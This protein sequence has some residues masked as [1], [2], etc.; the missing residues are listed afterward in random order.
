MIMIRISRLIWLLSCYIS[1]VLLLC[2]SYSCSNKLDI[3]EDFDTIKIV[4]TQGVGDLSISLK[5][6][7]FVDT[8]PAWCKVSIVN[9]KGKLVVSDTVVSLSNQDTCFRSQFL[10]LKSGYYFLKMCD[11]Y[12]S[13]NNLMYR[14][15]N[16]KKS[17]TIKSEKDKKKNIEPI[18]K[19]V[20]S[21][22]N[23]TDSF[24]FFAYY[25]DDKSLKFLH[26]DAT[27]TL[28]TNG[29]PFSTGSMTTQVTAV[30]IPRDINYFIL[31]VNNSLFKPYRDSISTT[32]LSLYKRIYPY[33]VFLEK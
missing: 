24:Y 20:H 17:N 25:F 4:S 30:F 5:N 23:K 14:L 15:D 32:D 7:D 29:I 8:V 26:V 18:F 12:D 3:K 11:I 22:D 16:S 1:V 31:T 6:T 2:V 33:S 28:S 9:K 19:A 27:Y 13:K 10:S 21:I